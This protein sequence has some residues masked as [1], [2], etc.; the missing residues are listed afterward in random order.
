MDPD[1]KLKSYIKYKIRK[2][3]KYYEVTSSEPYDCDKDGQ[4]NELYIDSGESFLDYNLSYIV[5]SKKKDVIE[6]IKTNGYRL[7]GTTFYYNHTKLDELI[8]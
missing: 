8:L 1:K 5:R 6:A 7:N 2:I 4:I 3:E